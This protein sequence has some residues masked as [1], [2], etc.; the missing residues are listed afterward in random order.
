MVSEQLT[1]D[2][3]LEAASSLFAEKSF[4]EVGIREIAKR[5]GCSHTT[6]YL[7]FKNKDEILFE[8]ASAPLEKLYQTSLEIYQSNES[9]EDRLLGVCHHFIRFGFQYASS[10]QLLFIVEGE[11]VD[12]PEFT[13]P[14]NQ[15]RMKS[16]NILKSLI[17]AVLPHSVSEE[18]LFNIVRGTY[19][20]L[21]GMVINYASGDCGYNERLQTIV[22]D[23]LTFTLLDRKNL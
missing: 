20:F 4:Q 22:T 10:N 21:Q 14:I 3:I 17:Q 16:F 9:V 1:R 11:E 15:L 7:Y 23:Y 19:L 6:I 13:K 18:K 2:R 5:A 8:V 12:L